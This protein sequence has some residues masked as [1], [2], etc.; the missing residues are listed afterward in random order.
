MKLGVRSARWVWWCGCWAAGVE[1]CGLRSWLRGVGVV[2]ALVAALTLGV[3]PPAAPAKASA[4]RRVGLLAS[5]GPSFSASRPVTIS[6]S[7]T[8]V[9]DISSGGNVEHEQTTWSVQWQGTLGQLFPKTAPPGGTQTLHG[10]TVASLKNSGTVT[11]KKAIAT[12]QG[13]VTYKT[14]T[15]SPKLVANGAPVVRVGSLYQNQQKEWVFLVTASLPYTFDLPATSG[16]K[17][18]YPSGPA[19]YGSEPIE[20]PPPIV[21]GVFSLAKG[22]TIPLNQGGPANHNGLKV[23]QNASLS[24][25]STACPGQ[26]STASLA[27]TPR[28]GHKIRQCCP[29]QGLTVKTLPQPSGNTYPRFEGTRAPLFAGVLCG[30]E[31]YHWHWK[32]ASVMTPDGKKSNRY[33][34]VTPRSKRD[35]PGNLSRLLVSLVCKKRRSYR[36]CWSVVK[37]DV[38]VTD[39]KQHH[40]S[41]SVAFFWQ[42]M[43]LPKGE[44]ARL[45]DRITQLHKQLT[46]ELSGQLN[47]QIVGFV[48]GFFFSEGVS[49]LVEA[50]SVVEDIVNLSA[51]EAKSFQEIQKTESALT[52]P[53]CK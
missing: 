34:T 20:G 39:A 22:G 1:A 32:L 16:C 52:M 19:S 50:P 31:P 44:R 24:V 35:Q 51:S 43:C 37:Y 8:Y 48:A 9:A 11:I 18:A 30:T 3:F 41:S 28:R 2:V 27:G 53:D 12:A 45:K 23:T 7:G 36:P 26:R 33:V 17:H 25:T 38:T 5:S 21:Q 49:S 42:A 4:L 29:S 6:Y 13:S 40:G 14:Y 10:V 15:C 46:N 47:G